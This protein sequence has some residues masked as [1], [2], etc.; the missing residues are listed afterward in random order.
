[1]TL[2]ED[3]LCL[4]S[5]SDDCFGVDSSSGRIFEKHPSSS[6]RDAGPQG[7]FLRTIQTADKPSRI[8]AAVVGGDDFGTLYGVYTLLKSLRFT[9]EGVVVRELQVADGRALSVR[10]FSPQWAWY[11]GERRAVRRRALAA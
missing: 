3:K 2:A 1:V 11:L 7:Y 9:A 4:A 8:V 5:R 6:A 10:G